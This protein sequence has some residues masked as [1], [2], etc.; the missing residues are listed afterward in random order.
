[1][2]TFLTLFLGLTAGLQ[3]VA[4]TVSAE[5]P[6][7][8][9]EIRLDGEA[10][11]VRNEPPWRFDVDLGE[12]APHELEAVAYG[13]DDEEIGRSAQPINREAREAS[14]GLAL[15]RD[16]SGE[17]AAVLPVWRSNRYLRPDSLTLTFDG[18]PLPVTDPGRIGLPTTDTSE[19][20]FIT[21]EAIA[22][23]NDTA[24]AELA[25]GGILGR[26]VSTRN[27]AAALELTGRR[28]LTRPTHARGLIEV[29]DGDHLPQQLRLTA[30]A[31]K[32][33]WAGRPDPP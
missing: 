14:L 32:L 9:V 18:E 8:R 5:T 29:V 15:D 19:L 12:L 10:V 20:H 23:D 22:P 24:T 27:T 21:A 7:E 13:P 16:V 6:V 31:E 30:A 4:V 28:R 11:A 1:M 25:Y 26:E 2:I 17:P 33:R 3:P